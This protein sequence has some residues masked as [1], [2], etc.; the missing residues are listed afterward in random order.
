[1]I[2]YS[3]HNNHFVIGTSFDYSVTRLRARAPLG[4]PARNYVVS[5]SGIFLGQSGDPVSIGPVATAHHQPVQRALCARTFDVT[6]AF[7]LTGGRAVQLR[8]D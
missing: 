1:M 8:A 5:G 6:N 4:T 7:S 3:G 2:S